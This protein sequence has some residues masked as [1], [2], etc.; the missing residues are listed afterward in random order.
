[1]KLFFVKRTD[2]IDYDEYDS[3]V[4]AAESEEAA[5]L[6]HP[7]RMV[8]YIWNGKFWVDKNY[9]EDEFFVPDNRGWA[10]PHSLVVTEIGEAN[11]G[12]TGI[13]C[14]SFNAG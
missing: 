7:S 11:A 4:C 14:A 2:S 5:R 1:M 12:V 13:I 6:I 3:F 8:E 10:S 9:Q